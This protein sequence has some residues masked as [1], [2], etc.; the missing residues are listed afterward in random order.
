MRMSSFLLPATLMLA[1]ACGVDDDDAALQGHPPVSLPATAVPDPV[2]VPSDAG[3]FLTW[4][5]DEFELE[6]GKE[7]YLCFTKTLE[8]DMV[9]DGYQTEGLPY[10]HHLIFSRNPPAW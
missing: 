6:A 7:R 8:E 9:I 1:V 3:E 2:Q 10:V 4:K 5:T